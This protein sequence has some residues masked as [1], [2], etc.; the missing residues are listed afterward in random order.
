MNY[1]TAVF[2]I[3]KHVRAVHVNYEPDRDDKSYSFKTLDETIIPGDFVIIPTD[4]RHKMTIGKVIAVDVDIDYD[5]PF[6]MKWII[7]KVDQSQYK[8]TLDQEAVAI[9]AIK[10]A[11]VRKKRDD[12]RAAMLANDP[13]GNIKLLAL[14]TTV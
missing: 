4:T 2:L 12:L 11:D 9:T 1:S 3:N 6:Q 5:A 8:T 14:S 7:G 10:A 13:D